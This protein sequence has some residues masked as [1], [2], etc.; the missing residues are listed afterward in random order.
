MNTPIC[1]VGY[2][3]SGTTLLRRLISM[4]P[5]MDYDIV[6]EEGGKFMKCISKKDAIEKLTFPSKQQG[7]LTGGTSSILAGQ[8]MPYDNIGF[9]KRYVTKFLDYFP[10]SL[11]L[12]IIRDPVYAINS[13][14]KTFKRNAPRC[15]TAYF[16]CVPEARRWLNGKPN[17]HEVSYECLTDNPIEELKRLYSIMGED[18]EEEL[19]TKIVT[20]KEPWLHDNKSMVGLRYFDSVNTRK[21]QDIVLK[22]N[23]KL[24]IEAKKRK[25]KWS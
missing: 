6:H 22:K 3:R 20:T 16:E 1:I 24:M 8:K 25:I 23:I 12:H 4:H 19:I 9:L 13:Q 18:V 21:K 7:E 15:V 14:V 2:E 10:D 11:I 5:M 17:S